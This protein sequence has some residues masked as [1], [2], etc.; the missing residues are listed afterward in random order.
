MQWMRAAL[1]G[2]D[3]GCKRPPAV[4]YAALR[5]TRHGESAA[6]AEP[7]AGSALRRQAAGGRQRVGKGRANKGS[8]MQELYRWAGG[9]GGGGGGSQ[10]RVEPVWGLWFS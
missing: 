2:S 9:G 5:H 3:R 7:P 10:A 1:L 4:W 8:S 6:C